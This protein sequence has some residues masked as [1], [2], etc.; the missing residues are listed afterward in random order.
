MNKVGLILLAHTSQNGQTDSR[1]YPVKADA[2]CLS[3]FDHS[4]E[5]TLK[6]LTLLRS[7]LPSH[8]KLINLWEVILSLLFLA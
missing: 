6:E 1:N 7:E 4:A 8:K 2:N 5:L 3:V